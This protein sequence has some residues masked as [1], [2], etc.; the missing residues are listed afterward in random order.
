MDD[1]VSSRTCQPLASGAHSLRT[2]RTLVRLEASAAKHSPALVARSRLSGT[3]D[4]SKSSA[5]R[6]RPL[7]LTSET[8]HGTLG[9][10]FAYAAMH[11]S[12]IPTCFPTSR[13]VM[14][15]FI[16]N[17]W[18]EGWGGGG[19]WVPFHM[20]RR[21]TL[22]ADLRCHCPRADLSVGRCVSFELL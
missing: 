3:S 17:A 18:R 12:S 20:G 22:P 9:L 21:A 13:A 11:M 4:Q 2:R 7:G 19:G 16:P 10:R 15:F 6:S 8:S 14:R 5:P 1:E